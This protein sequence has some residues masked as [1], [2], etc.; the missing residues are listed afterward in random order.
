M[1]PS[2]KIIDTTTAIGEMVELL[3][4]IPKRS[5][6]YVRRPRRH[7]PFASRL[8]LDHANLVDVHTLGHEAF[9]HP[10]TRGQTLKGILEDENI[11]KVFFVFDVRNDPDA[12]Y[13][14]FS[15]HLAGIQDIQLIELATRSG[16]RRFINGLVRCIERDAGLTRSETSVWR[17]IKR[18][19]RA[20]VCA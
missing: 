15:V 13:A 19:W 16:S 6:I 8:N 9:F 12:L 7:K 1:D 4:H 14:H 3:T 11:Q 2:L 10:C 17:D 18:E 5:S 20:A